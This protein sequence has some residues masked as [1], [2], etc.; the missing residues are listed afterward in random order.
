MAQA[1]PQTGPV[2]MLLHGFPQFWWSWRGVLPRLA[3]AG[4]RTV[5]MD[6][7]GVGASDKPPRGY[8]TPT[9][10][11][12][13]AG[14]VRSLG[15][16]RAVLVASGWSA[17]ISWSAPILAPATVAA[18]A[19]LGGVHPLRSYA[20]A[21]QHQHLHGL[22]RMAQLQVPRLPERQ[23][24]EGR[25]VADILRTW[26]GTQWPA[27]DELAR[28]QQAMRI[29]SAAHC[30]LESFRWA[31]RSRMRPD[32]ARFRAQVARGVQVPVL[33]LHGAHDGALGTP[34]ARSSKLYANGRYEFSEI[35]DAG[36]FLAD[37]APDQVTEAL[38]DWLPRLPD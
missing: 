16:N 28:Y 30:A 7:R 33:Q 4:Y 36:H 25:L 9:M 27:A 15:A 12:D 37:A 21:A 20:M 1:G 22:R 35:A 31:A 6:L 2:V 18:V 24:R 29:P 3:D 14:V 23:L 11:R 5:A 34:V 10:V 38:L 19:V 8:D 17:W 26:S 13:V 32:G